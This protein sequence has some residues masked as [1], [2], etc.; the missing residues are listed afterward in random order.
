MIHLTLQEYLVGSPDLFSNAR[1]KIAEVCLTYLN[2]QSI[3]DLPPDIETPPKTAPFLDYASC[4]WGVHARKELTGH[5]KSLALKLLD[6]FGHH[7]A[8]RML[9][10][11]SELRYLL[12]PSGLELVTGRGGAGFDTS[13]PALT[14]SGVN[15][16]SVMPVPPPSGAQPMIT[17]W[18]GPLF[19]PPILDWGLSGGMGGA[20]ARVGKVPGNWAGGPAVSGSRRPR[21]ELY[22]GPGDS[23]TTGLHVIAYFGIAEI[24]RA[25]IK[26]SGWEVNRRDCLDYT[27]LMWAARNNNQDVCEALLESGGADPGIADGA[28]QKPLFAASQAGHEGIV[29]LLLERKD[30]NPNSSDMHNKTPL[31]EAAWGGHEG[32]LQL[33]IE[34]KDVNPTKPG[35]NGRAPLSVASGLGNEGI[36]KLL[37]ELLRTDANSPAPCDEGAHSP[38]T[39]F[40][41]NTPSR[42]LTPGPLCDGGLGLQSYPQEDVSFDPL[43]ISLNDRDTSTN[44]HQVN[45]NYHRSA[46]S[47]LD[48][49]PVPELIPGLPHNDD[50]KPPPHSQENVSIDP[51]NI[52]HNNYDST[53]YA[54]SVSLNY[55]RLALLSLLLFLWFIHPLALN[56][57]LI[58]GLFVFFLASP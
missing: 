7:V 3:K 1:S 24:S 51:L 53:T 32:I 47:L 56:A 11:N 13:G 43:I 20:G 34:R 54:P 8:A 19:S 41:N 31:L 28:R 50:V 52:S 46:T 26:S 21:N 5:T 30:V 25:M 22:S 57:C 42:G 16:S 15:I 10:L 18:M 35:S 45:S 29:K 38:A 48:N 33:L 55:L 17:T 9:L 58:L 4:Y 27:P 36:V 37:Q 6:Q 12:L 40:I 44:F 2:F 49:T 23:G 39:C 14:R